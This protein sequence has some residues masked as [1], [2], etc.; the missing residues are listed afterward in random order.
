MS[1]LIKKTIAAGVISALLVYLSL[2]G[3]E[4]SAVIGGLAGLRNG[5]VAAALAAMLLMQILRAWRWGI[6]LSP[7]ARLGW[8][9]LF[10]ISNVGFLAI[11]AV[12][13]RLGELVRPYLAAKRSDLGMSAAL[14]TIVAERLFDTATIVAISLV[15]VAAAPLPS[16]LISWGYVA[17]F[18]AAV[19]IVI[20]ALAAIRKWD[21][22][23]PFLPSLGR[24]LPAGFSGKIKEAL[25]RFRGGFQAL[26]SWRLILA[27]ASGSL[28]IWLVDVAAIYLL[29]LAFGFPLSLTAA[30]VVMVI[31]LVGIALPAAPGFVG[32]W[33]YSCV[34]GLTILGIPKPEALTFALV[35]HFLSIAVL[36]LMGVASLPFSPLDLRDLKEGL[37]TGAAR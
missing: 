9:D 29:F 23:I 12:P 32:N 14:G 15:V 22:P 27:V 19:G 31:L 7:L 8:R 25:V 10:S 37:K 5:Y 30:F 20:M 3:V 34:L 2:R 6:I 18:F 11:V 33:H 21:C 13:A 36:L 4:F 17:L 24:R 26:S 28:L 35:Y 1:S 16:G